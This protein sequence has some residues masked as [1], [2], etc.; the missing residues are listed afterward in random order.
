MFNLHFR[1]FC[2]IEE[3]NEINSIITM[4][5]IGWTADMSK[6]LDTKENKNTRNFL[7]F[8]QKMRD[9]SS[10]IPDDP[11]KEVFID[12]EASIE[13]YAAADFIINYSAT[14]HSQQLEYA[15]ENINKA[16]LFAMFRKRLNESILE[17]DWNLIDEDDLA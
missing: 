16:I 12:F 17:P 14:Y 7:S 15:D 13:E 5:N 4:I 10:D 9:G 1:F 11:E 8:A 6:T 2:P 3:F